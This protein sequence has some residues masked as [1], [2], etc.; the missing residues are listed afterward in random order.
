MNNYNNKSII[1]SVNYPNFKYDLIKGELKSGS[2]IANKEHPIKYVNE[3][4]NDL[5]KK[6]LLKVYSKEYYQ[7]KRT[8]KTGCLMAYN[9]EIFIH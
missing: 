4:R 5:L 2:L 6:R 3:F 1:H 7:L 8:I 9:L